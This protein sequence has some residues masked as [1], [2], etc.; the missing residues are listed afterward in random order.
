[1]L[2][3]ADSSPVHYLVLI[4]QTDLF[5]KL[6]G[7]IIIPEQVAR[8]LS[9][10]NAPQSVRDLIDHPPDWLKVRSPQSI[11]HIPKIDEGEEAAISLA[12]EAHADL[13]LI[14]DLDGRE[15]ARRLGLR[16]IGTLGVLELAAGRGLVDL[17][18]VIRDLQDASMRLSDALVQSV[19]DRHKKGRPPG[20]TSNPPK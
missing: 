16:I 8:E 4:H 1:M 6:F 13:L 17:P 19:L 11:E 15:A 3:V 14:D 10:P 20:N 9:H 7:E 12:R 2:V 5:P 18:T